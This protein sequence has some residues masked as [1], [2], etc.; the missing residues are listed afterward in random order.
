[1]ELTGCMMLS[2]A[3]HFCVNVTWRASPRR[4]AIL[5]EKMAFHVPETL[6]DPARF[7]FASLGDGNLDHVLTIGWRLEGDSKDPWS[8]RFLDAKTGSMAAKK[9]AAQFIRVLFAPAWANA[10]LVLVPAISSGDRSTN[11]DSVMALTASALASARQEHTYAGS[12]LLHKPHASLTNTKGRES[13]Q[14]TVANTYSVNPAATLNLDNRNVLLI[15]DLVTNAHTLADMARAIKAHS[16]KVRK[17]VGLCFGKNEKAEY[18]QRQ[19]MTITNNHLPPEYA[20]L[21]DEGE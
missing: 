20:R 17:I 11:P 16:P 9:R 5:G 21:W 10:E 6:R 15:D 8:R 3:K 19:G 7:K 14:A 12:L 13:R 1:M 18:A 4:R 2:S